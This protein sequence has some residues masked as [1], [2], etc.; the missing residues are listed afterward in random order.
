LLTDAAVQKK[1]TSEKDEANR[2][3]DEDPCDGVR[4]NDQVPELSI[5]QLM[6]GQATVSALN[7][8]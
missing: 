5:W 4:K 3:N 1:V 6:L 2:E 7:D 8:H